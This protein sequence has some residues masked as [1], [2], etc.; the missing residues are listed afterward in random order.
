MSKFASEHCAS[1]EKFYL[2]PREFL[3]TDGI[4]IEYNS[5]W[6]GQTYPT[7]AAIF[8][9]PDLWVQVQCPSACPTQRQLG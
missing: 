7:N 2:N 1:L 8:L 9:V 5:K 3:L 6:F 4:E